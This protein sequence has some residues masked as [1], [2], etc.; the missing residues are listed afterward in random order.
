[1]RPVGALLILGACLAISAV[2]IRERRGRLRT[3]D[4]L[5]AALCLMEAEIGS[6]AAALPELAG[7]LATRCPGGAARFFQQLSGS[8]DALGEQTFYSLWVFCVR[9]ALPELK[10]TERQPL[11]ELGRSLGRYSL[12][13]QTK[14]IRLCRERIRQ[15]AAAARESFA[16][17][18]RLIW[19]L[20]FAGGAFLLIL[21]L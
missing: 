14:A 12:D 17:D 20:S 21:L 3:L 7:F 2:G 5:D 15:E 13:C 16:R 18:S 1:M 11:L 9:Q 10:E 8:L 4:G 6:R 19:G